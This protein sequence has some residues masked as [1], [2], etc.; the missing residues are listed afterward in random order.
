MSE[1][2]LDAEI[3]QELQQVGPTFKDIIRYAIAQDSLDL[4]KMQRLEGRYIDK[5]GMRHNVL[6]GPCSCGAYHAGGE[7]SSHLKPNPNWIFR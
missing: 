6:E 5:N 4:E 1:K 7:Y 2:D 3:N